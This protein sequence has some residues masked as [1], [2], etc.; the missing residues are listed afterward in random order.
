MPNSLTTNRIILK[1][2]VK[3]AVVQFTTTVS[4]G[5]GFY[6]GE[7]TGSIDASELSGYQ[8]TNDPVKIG[9]SKL[10]WNTYYGDPSYNNDSASWGLYW[11]MTGATGMTASPILFLSG[12]GEI[13]FKNVVGFPIRNSLT[14][15]YNNSIY[16]ENLTHL[17]A[18]STKKL[19]LI[20]EISKI[21]GFGLTQAQ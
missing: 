11:G 7:I 5:A 3:T 20:L 16:I 9:I 18:I 8:L 19:N 10:S 15:N 6:A 12:A 1:D 4:D 14:G 21:S 2:T 17:A 13:N